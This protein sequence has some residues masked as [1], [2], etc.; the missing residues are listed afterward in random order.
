MRGRLSALEGPAS[1]SAWGPLGRRAAAGRVATVCG[2]H[3]SPRAAPPRLSSPRPR[4]RPPAECL[5]KPQRIRPCQLP[6]AHRTPPRAGRGRTGRLRAP[7]LC[8]APSRQVASRSWRIAV[9]AAAQ[10]LVRPPLAVL[11]WAGGTWGR[12]PNMRKRR[13]EASTASGPALRC[14]I[15]V[16][17]MTLQ[18][19]HVRI[20]SAE[21]RIVVNKARCT[22]RSIDSYNVASSRTSIDNSYLLARVFSGQGYSVL[23][24]RTRTH[25]KKAGCFYAF[26][27]VH[28]WICLAIL[29]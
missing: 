11:R 6:S 16:V 15:V 2:S 17:T 23:C 3:P 12:E 18:G 5:C 9:S 1:A 20:Q 22:R 28:L 19:W 7:R 25:S 29:H 13:P 21:K 14:Y 26:C 24:T 8:P 27:E 4:G 10:V